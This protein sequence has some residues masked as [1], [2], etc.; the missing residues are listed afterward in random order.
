MVSRKKLCTPY[1]IILKKFENNDELK[2]YLPKKWELL[3]DVL[4]LRI[5]N[6]LQKYQY[7]IGECYADVLHAKTVVNALS[8]HGEYRLPNVKIIYGNNTETIHKENNILFKLDVSKIMFS[9]GNIYER[10]R[11]AEYSNKN[12]TVVDMFAGIG[13]FS[14]PIAKYS[15]PKKIYA[16]EKNPDAYHYL[17]ENIK[18][19]KLNNVVPILSDCRNADENIADR[20]IMGYLKDTHIFLPKAI[21]ILNDNGI[22]HYHENVVIELFDEKISQIKKIFSNE[23][24][25]M[26]IIN[27]RVVKSYAPGVSHVVMDIFVYR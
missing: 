4:L 24:K 12:E 20:I 13:Y 27:Y 22:I 7:Q 18:L 8:I 15:M 23:N 14:I 16:Y 3:G 10:N 21:K 9:S 5:P 6:P 19:N 11:I 25:N 17:C 1:E 2:K 26:K